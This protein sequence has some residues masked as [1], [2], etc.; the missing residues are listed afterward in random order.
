MAKDYNI[1]FTRKN[2]FYT[3]NEATWRRSR[4]AYGGGNKYIHQGLIKHMSE[5]K[6]EFDERL[7]RA[8]YLNYP[9]RIAMLITQCVLATRPQ[10]D[11]ADSDIVED[12]SRTGLRVDEVMRQFCT[13]MN[14]YGCAWLAVDMPRFDGPKTKEDEQKERLRPYCLALNPLQVLDWCYGMDGQLEWVLM[15]EDTLDNTDPFAQPKQMDVRKLWTR[16]DVTI[17]T[18]NKATGEQTETILPHGLECVPFI[19]H[20]EVDGY[21]I[22]ENHWFEDVVRISDA[23]L[24]DGSEAQMNV[25]KQMFGL[26]VVPEDFIDGIKAQQQEDEANNERP[27]DEKLSHVLAR[28]AALYESEAGKGCCR[29]IAP[30]GA[31]TATIRSE[32]DALRR[33]LFNVVGL[34]LAKDT[35][36]VESAEAKAWDFQAVEQYM[37]TRADVLEQCE[38]QAWK[39]LAMWMPTIKVPT[40][41]YNRNFA[42]LD[43]K[44]AIAAL[45]E[46]S[47][48]NQDNDP[49]QREIGKTAL[50][51]LNR[52][53]QLPPSV[54]KAVLELIDKSTPGKDAAEQQRMVDDM[55]RQAAGGAV[56]VDN[57][58]NAG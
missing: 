58:G 57:A 54:E 8:Y 52:L 3:D 2:K 26:L 22:G 10:R 44:E 36:M 5:I 33:E 32:I 30:S 4:D 21:G 56:D 9:R 25:V 14:V 34:A 39:L 45:L 48:F 35:K 24:N 46:L 1:L 47:G 27:K 29:Y 43:L 15:S 42:I 13:F 31:E 41:S 51:L 55:K 16:Q 53:R 40:I 38:T 12:F 17:V 18:R 50:S 19:R 23:M 20:V 49:Y 6:P 7:A 37:A 11:G 28:S